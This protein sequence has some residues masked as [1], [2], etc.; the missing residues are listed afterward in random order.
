MSDAGSALIQPL[1]AD[2]AYARAAA[3][4]AV[5]AD[6]VAGGA[7]VNF[8]HPYS[9]AQGEAFYREVADS[10]AAGNTVLLAAFQD[11]RIVG[12]VQVQFVLK[13]NQLHRVEIAKMLVHP[14]ARRRGIAAALMRAAEAEALKAGRWLAGMRGHPGLCALARGRAVQRDHFL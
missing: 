7:S 2:E 8:M 10:V 6:C 12:T 11:G 13:P 4:G 1:T 9:V 5:L 3:L 14:S